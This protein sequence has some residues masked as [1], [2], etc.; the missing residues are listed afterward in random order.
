[1]EKDQESANDNRGQKS[2]DEESEEIE[3]VLEGVVSQDDESEGSAEPLMVLQSQNSDLSDQ[4]FTTELPENSI[5]HKKQDVEQQIIDKVELGQHD[6][7]QSIVDPVISDEDD[8]DRLESGNILTKTNLREVVS[9]TEISE[10]AM[11]EPASDR[12]ILVGNTDQEILVGDTDTRDDE[13]QDNINSVSDD[14]E[15]NV[16]L[17][18]Y[19]AFPASIQKNSAAALYVAHIESTVP[20]VTMDRSFDTDEVLKAV[21]DRESV[22]SDIFEPSQPEMETSKQPGYSRYDALR[23]KYTRPRPPPYRPDDPKLTYLPARGVR[24]Y[25]PFLKSSPLAELYLDNEQVSVH[26][27]QITV[28]VHT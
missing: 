24:S 14:N 3:E 27:Q 7:L 1:M 21:Y 17:D 4:E 15:L 16:S 19:M 5:I 13:S 9:D 6:T 8:S 18:N 2:E 28:G 26:I 20:S 10:I 11:Q 25:A 22:V 12:E 23:S